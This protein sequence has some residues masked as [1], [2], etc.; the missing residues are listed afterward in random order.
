MAKTKS[1]GETTA[2]KSAAKGSTAKKAASTKAA[3]ST[4]KATAKK[5]AGPK[6]SDPQKEMLKRVASHPDQAG[7]R[8]EKKPENKTLETLLK[9]K[10]VKR[11]A[12]HKESGHYHYQVSN[13]GQKHLKSLEGAGT[14]TSTA[15]KT[16]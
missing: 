12:K 2:K 3:G 11:G 15:P 5:A 4:K 16:S 9:H 14:G 6:L 1:A 10:L 13:A 8:A 7:Y